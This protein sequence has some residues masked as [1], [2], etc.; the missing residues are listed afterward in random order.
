MQLCRQSDQ[1]S[2]KHEQ[3]QLNTKRL[4]ESEL[5][6]GRRLTVFQLNQSF[7]AKTN[8]GNNGFEFNPVSHFKHV[9]FVFYCLHFQLMLYKFS[10]RLHQLRA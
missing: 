2:L 1:Y 10:D 8:T 3:R 5:E 4:L 7:G 6:A 9:S